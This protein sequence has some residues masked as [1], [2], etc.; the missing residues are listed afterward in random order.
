VWSLISDGFNFLSSQSWAGLMSLFW[1]TI[2]FDVPRYMLSFLAATISSPIRRIP[3]E[4]ACDLGKVSAVLAGHNEADGIERCVRSLHEQSR[5]PDE[6]IVVSDGSTD[7]MSAKLQQLCKEGIVDQAHCTQ[8]RGGKSAALNLGE[9][10][11]TGDIII[12]ADCDSTYHRHALRNI[13]KPLIDPAVGAVSGSI[14]VRNA[15]QTLITKFQAIEYLINISL[16][17]QASALNDQVTCVSGAFGAFRR[18]ALESVNGVDVGGGEDFDLTLKLRKAGW[19]VEFAPEAICYTDTPTTLRA[20]IRQRLRWERDTVRLRY[21]KHIDLVNPFSRKFKLTEL[22]HEVEFFVFDMGGA[23]IL[24]IYIVWLFLTYGELALTILLAVQA[25]LFFLDLL[26]FILAA[27]ST[28][29]VRVMNLLPYTLGYSFFC[30][31][32]MRNVRLAAYFQEWLFNA[33]ASDE[34]LPAKI[35]LTRRW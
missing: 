5:R 14:L 20:L 7:E 27:L 10:Y 17:K 34:Y 23:V 28:P 2:L 33:S 24:P 1:F 32:M 18:S 25:G 4:S 26:S 8:L 9:R 22:L 19:K 12:I 30:G 6:I 16:G 29:W 35:R 11:A 13:L 15:A 3:V 31:F 21:R